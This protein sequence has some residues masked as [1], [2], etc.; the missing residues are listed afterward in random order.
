MGTICPMKAQTTWLSACFLSHLWQIMR[1]I[2]QRA[3]QTANA[4]RLTSSLR[5]WIVS[6]AMIAIS[7]AHWKLAI[8][9]SQFAKQRK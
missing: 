5:I 1:R 7:C 6:S 8:R 4:N 2:V 9:S 3:S